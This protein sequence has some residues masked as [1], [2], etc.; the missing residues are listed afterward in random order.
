MIAPVVVAAQIALASAGGTLPAAERPMPLPKTPPHS[1]VT[2]GWRGLQF[3]MGPGD[4]AA[5]LRFAPGTGGLARIDR[6]Y[7]TAVLA[8]PLAGKRVQAKFEFYRDHLNGIYITRHL[9]PGNRPLYDEMRAWQR[10]VKGEL[11]KMYGTPKCGTSSRDPVFCYWERPGKDM[12]A[13]GLRFD[14][15]KDG[16]WDV[17]ISIKAD[18][19][20][21][22]PWFADDEP[23]ALAG[24]QQKCMACD[25]LLY[26][27]TEDAAL[28]MSCT[29]YPLFDAM[30]CRFTRV[31]V[32]ERGDDD[33]KKDVIRAVEK[34]SDW[35]KTRDQACA[36]RT[37]V[38][39]ATA[40]LRTP[41]QRRLGERRGQL[42][43]EVCTCTTEQ[44]VAEAIQT[45]I[46]FFVSECH[47]AVRGIVVEVARSGPSTWTGKADSE[48]LH[49]DTFVIEKKELPSASSRGALYRVQ[50]TRTD[51]PTERMGK[52]EDE[53]SA[54]SSSARE[55][56]LPRCGSMGFSEY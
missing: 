37:K 16:Y 36:E 31:S 48:L 47:V 9:T 30:T 1:W 8:D 5:R 26:A 20:E 51:T 12:A 14:E 44:C 50:W 40:S 43:N 23:D 2:R 29:G 17:T 39:T 13:A 46:P 4:V 25:E 55:D 10:A 54:W 32:K 18:S 53:V 35:S 15:G 42:L 28:S 33:V 21:S 22:A 11:A 52:P 49:S 19:E 6:M 45:A 3:G 27:E 41:A 38:I 34:A 56:F 24:P 7:W